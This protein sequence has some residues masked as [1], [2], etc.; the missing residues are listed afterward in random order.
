MAAESG[1][2]SERAHLTD[3]SDSLLG[4]APASRPVGSG[5]AGKEKFNTISTEEGQF[6]RQQPAFLLWWLEISASVL[7]VLCVAANAAFL[8]A[9]DRKPYRSLRIS[10]TDITPNTVI[11]ILSALS[12]SSLLLAVAEAIGQLNGVTFSNDRTSW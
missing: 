2:S 10:G 3:G 4:E 6:S 5:T 1:V 8:G 11:A 12:K 7:S 9:I